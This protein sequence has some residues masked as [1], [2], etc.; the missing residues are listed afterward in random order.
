[1]STDIIAIGGSTLFKVRNEAKKIRCYLAAFVGVFN[2]LSAAFCQC[3][4]ED[5]C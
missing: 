3:Y 1:M 2:V 5:W 4:N